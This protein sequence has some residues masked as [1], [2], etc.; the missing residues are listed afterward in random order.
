MHSSMEDKIVLITGANSGIGKATAI[1][2]AKMGAEIIM[3]TR[4]EIAGTE[5]LREIGE[6][7]GSGKLHAYTCDLSSLSQVR[8]L[9]LDLH[10]NF[11]RIDVLIN[12]AGIITKDRI[13]TEDG[14]EY[15]FAVNHLAHFLLTQLVVDLLRNSKAARIVNVSSMAHKAGKIHYSDLSL[16]EGYSPL[17]AYAQS[18][19][20]N[21]LFTNALSSRLVND[22]IT[23]NAVHPGMVGSRFAFGRN[24]QSTHWIMKLYQKIAKTPEK[25]AETSIFLAS[26]SN[27]EKKSGGYYIN[28]KAVPSSKSSYDPDATIALWNLSLKM[29][30]L[31]RSRI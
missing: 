26:S 4:K 23:S 5:T 31:E 29:C 20:A 22:G 16:E 28:N 21:I 30:G 25:G 12:N 1:A 11:D 13:L 24:G 10:E 17:K 6:E 3:V 19:L 8:K 15:Q 2:L 9:S 7:T 18:K 14:F 27:L